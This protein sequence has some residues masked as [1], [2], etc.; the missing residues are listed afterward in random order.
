MNF[1]FRKRKQNQCQAA[2]ETPYLSNSPQAAESNK[3]AAKIV[4]EQGYPLT[5]TKAGQQVQLVGMRHCKIQ[6]LLNKEL[7]L[8]DVLK[9]LNVRPSGSI[10]VAVG[11]AQLCIGSS[12]AQ[13]L[14]V[15]ELPT[16]AVEA[17][18]QTSLNELAVGEVGKVVSY[19]QAAQG[20]KGRLLSMG[21]TPSTEFTVTRVAPLADPIAIRVRGFHLSLRRQEAVGVIVE[22]L[23]VAKQPPCG[24]HTT[25]GDNTV[26]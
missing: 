3:K 6:R 20:Y 26:D 1:S 10:M 17:T 21:L 15:T 8:G 19:T 24:D 18:S 7:V 22:R 4:N 25:G 13:D 23:N 2:K 12:L 5:W 9:V 11:D 14:L 16:S